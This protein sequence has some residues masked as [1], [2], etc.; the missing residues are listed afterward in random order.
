MRSATECAPKKCRCGLRLSKPTCGYIDECPSMLK[1]GISFP[2]REHRRM[3]R[4][5]KIWMI[6]CTCGVTHVW[7]WHTKSNGCWKIRS[8]LPLMDSQE[9]TVV[10]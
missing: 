7:S 5:D 6:R 3:F 8:V 10:A 1:L 9:I 4:S 2:G